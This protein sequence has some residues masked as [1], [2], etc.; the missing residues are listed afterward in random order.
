MNLHLE[1]ACRGSVNREHGL[2]KQ[3]ALTDGSLGFYKE[4]KQKNTTKIKKK[5][6]KI[7]TTNFSENNLINIMRYT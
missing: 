5:K 4:T 6:C 2:E 1:G 3:P 7:H